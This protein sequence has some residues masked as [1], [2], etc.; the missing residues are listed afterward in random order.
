MSEWE[1]QFPTAEAGTA[2]PD[3]IFLHY[4]LLLETGF[5]AFIL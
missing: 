5:P 3:S 4:Y 1:L 2:V